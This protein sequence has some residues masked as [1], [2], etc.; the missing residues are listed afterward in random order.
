M[1]LSPAWWLLGLFFALMGGCLGQ[2]P[3]DR[4]SP[5]RQG[6]RVV[7]SIPPLADFV[8]WVTQGQAQVIVLV[9]PQQSPHTFE[10]R[11]SQVRAL[12]NADLVVFNGRGLEPWA[13]RL[14]EALPSQVPVLYITEDPA[15]AASPYGTNAHLWLDPTWAQ[16]YLTV[17]RDVL[18]ELHPQEAGRWQ[19]GWE[20]GSR[21]LQD[22]K[23]ELEDL[24]RP[25]PPEA[26]KVA[27]VHAAWEPLLRPLGFQLFPLLEG[28]AFE[29]GGHDVPPQQLLH[30]TQELRAQGARAI[31]VEMQGS[32]GVWQTLAQEVGIP[33]VPLDPLGGLLGR[34]G[35]LAMM[36]YNVSTLVQVLKEGAP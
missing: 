9:K 5:E 17:L 34:E 18:Q 23:Q 20:N 7:V 19:Q 2:R 30:W 26:R 35:Y 15:F 6:L 28:E 12:L 22:L 27:L 1:R 4:P 36:R 31:I 21:Q 14:V 24:V 33:L 13:A 3:A 29:E 25:L 8:H 16:A 10:P 11:P 32:A